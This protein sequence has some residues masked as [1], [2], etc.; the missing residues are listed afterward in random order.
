MSKERT[1]S[2]WR[3]WLWRRGDDG[4]PKENGDTRVVAPPVDLTPNDPLFYYL[5]HA[6]GVVDVDALRLDSP[7]LTAMRRAGVKLLVPLV[8]QGELI[9]TINVGARLSEQEY[10][11]EDRRLLADLA[12]QAAPAVR[13]AQLAQKQE[14]A[15]RERERLGQELRIARLIQQTLLPKSLPDLPGWSLAAHYQPARAV[16]GDFYDVVTLDDGRVA[17]VIGDVTDKGVPA[18][19]VMATTRAI[20][21]GAMR[22]STAPGEIL[23]RTNELL[24][25]DIP[26]KMFVTCLC[27]V[28]EPGSGRL[29]YANAGHDLPYLR[30]AGGVSELRATGMP[31]GLMPGMRYE[32]REATVASGESVLFYSDG[33]VEAHDDERAMYGF[34]R[35]RDEVAAHAG[36]VGLIP[37]L[38]ASLGAF[39]GDGRE[40][41]DDVTLMV[42]RRD[43]AVATVVDAAPRREGESERV[44]SF[45]IPSRPGNER[46]V[47]ERVAEAVAASPRSWQPAPDR[48]ERLGA[49]VAEAAMN[50]IEHGNRN[51]PEV[52]V[53][54]R[55]TATPEALTVRIADHGQPHD[56]GAVP[57][58]DI[59]AKLEGL[60]S[61]RGW[62]LFLMRAMVD[63]V[64]E[65]ADDG[66]H[67][68]ELVVRRRE[69]DA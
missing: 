29:V 39:V 15:A 48:L 13:V 65:T 16:G 17:L 66:L 32:E 6:G 11:S 27:A 51:D 22:T 33:L 63:E 28:L 58:P 21:R 19:L 1:R 3:F 38:L 41:E 7:G 56:A 26:P 12:S 49:A 62:G 64:N 57:T 2:R 25:P 30:G 61:P 68:V 23:G 54:V 55:V 60:Q 24:H 42:L 59:E 31:L 36:R 8:S 18:A 40:Q 46:A 37:Y 35:L 34:G 44:T 69:G 47:M 67:A 4:R 43:A 10:S 14:A 53:R 50:A 45:D 52:P 20:L 9:G 5:Q